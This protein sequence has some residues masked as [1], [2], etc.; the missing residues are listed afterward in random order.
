M[1]EKGRKRTY[2]WKVNMVVVGFKGASSDD[3]LT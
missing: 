3:A 2:G 1:T